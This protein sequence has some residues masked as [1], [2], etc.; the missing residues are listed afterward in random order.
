MIEK[1]ALGIWSDRPTDLRQ[2]HDSSPSSAVFVVAFGSIDRTPDR[3]SA[4]PRIKR[5]FEPDKSI[6]VHP[7]IGLTDRHRSLLQSHSICHIGSE[8]GRC[9]GGCMITPP[10]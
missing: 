8:K 9:P 10:R 5:W 7:V 1:E 2:D 6:Q 4:I 3:A